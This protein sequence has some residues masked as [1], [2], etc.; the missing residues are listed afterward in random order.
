MLKVCWRNHCLQNTPSQPKE[1]P[2]VPVLQ[3]KLFSITGVW[4]W[5]SKW[6]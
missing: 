3:G 6:R 2:Q 4:D 1:Y 5:S